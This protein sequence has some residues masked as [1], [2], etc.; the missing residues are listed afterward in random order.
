MKRLKKEKNSKKL[1]DKKPQKKSKCKK[2]IWMVMI[3]ILLFGAVK[4]A[5]SIHQWQ[6]MVKAMCV[7]Q[8]SQVLDLEGK[9]V[10]SIGSERN[11]QN[12][13]FSEIPENLKNAYVSIEDERF[14]RHFGI[15]IKRTVAAIGSYVIRWGD[16]SFGASTITQQLVKNLTGDDSNRPTRK[17]KEWAK[18]IELEWCMDKD[19]ILETYLNIIY[20]G[21]NIYGVQKGANYYFDKNVSD[22]DLAE[23]AFLAGINNA[24]NAYNPFKEETDNTEK[25]RKRTKTVLN[26]MLEL[27]T[28]TEQDY[29]TAVAKVE[30]GL[31]FQKGK[32]EP[33]SDGVYSYHTDALLL[34]VISDLAEQKK[35]S[36]TFATNY[37]YMAN[38]NIY[39]TQNS[40]IQTEIEKEFEKN[41][42]R[43]KS[44][45]SEETAQAAM[46]MMDHKTG[47]VLACV[48]GLGEKREAR[49]FNRATQAIRQTGSSSK[50]LAVII[51]ALAEKVITPV[52]QYNDELTTFIDYNKEAYSPTNYNDYL[53]E[54]TVRRAVESSQNI[55][56]VKI[57]EEVTAGTSIQYLKRMGI[58]TLNEKDENLALS[59]GGLD[60]GISPLEMAGA[61][62]TIAN[63]GVYLAPT[64]YT[65]ITTDAGE[66]VLVSKQTKKRAFSADVAYVTKKLLTQPV[67]GSHGTATYCAIPG[68]EVAAKTGTTNEDYDRWLCG[69]TNYYTAVTWF[70]FDQSECI[71]YNGKNPAGMIW[72]SVM[73]R[74]HK[75][76]ENSDFKEEKSVVSL[77]ICKK[78]LKVANS[79]CTDVFTEY[80]IKGCIPENCL[81]HK[82]NAL[83]DV[84]DEETKQTIKEV[85]K[86]T[87]DTVK[88]EINRDPETPPSTTQEPPAFAPEQSTNPTPEQPSVTP[89]EEPDQQETIPEE[90]EPEEYTNQVNNS[91]SEEEK[92]EEEGN[93]E[94]VQNEV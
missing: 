92:K 43:L 80:F 47:Y 31:P 17:V 46:V 15:D 87:V 73:T 78:S 89:P 4:M 48:G 63:D 34:E 70:G 7:N 18:A 93:E 6:E 74:V 28:I 14:Y 2:I 56:F 61:Y 24:P 42:Y 21:P 53:G 55:P 64:F 88:S 49:G 58:S 62:S 16:A 30:N 77:K 26:K 66:N 68:M 59:L 90:K 86:S 32:L 36:K 22:L 91:I 29:H 65:K 23:C 71:D 57:M 38:A 51:P 40:E 84:V 85:V 50:P 35:I 20:V 52:S 37:L 39:S 9:V 76:L 82:G 44:K 12:V 8:P 11:R 10:A 13:S 94:M 83:Q 3:S 1:Q 69:F 54:I 60:K 19:E 45:N 72:S 5:L 67:V 25:I 27:E 81:M 41:K 79:G 75:K 33:E